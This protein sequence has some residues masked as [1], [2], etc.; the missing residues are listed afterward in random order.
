MLA[1]DLNLLR[2]LAWRNLWR[3]KR[4]TYI[5]LVAISLGAWFMLFTAA[6]VRGMI[7]QQL[8][9]A[10]FTLT[11]HV[12]IHQKKYRDD[13][14]IEHSMSPPGAKLR[15][16]LGDKRISQWSTRVRLPAVIISERESRGT[17][18]VGIDPAHEQG[19]SFI[20]DPVQL[21]RN[22]ESVDDSGVVIGRRMAKR[23]QTEIG[24][25]IVIMA[26][27]ENGDVADRGFRIVGLFTAELEATETAYVFTGR[28]VA[29][30][31]LKMGDKISEIEVITDSRDGLQKLTN[32]LR[33]AAPE[34]ETMDWQELQ[35][36]L[37]ATVEFYD[38][39][40]IIW[41]LIVFL[42][43]SFGLVNTLLMAVFERTRELGLFQALGMR[44]RY[45]VGQV[46][47]ESVILMVLGLVAGNL[48]SWLS[49]IALADGVDLSN[50]AQGLEQF[51]MPTV[52]KLAVTSQDVI[53]AN[54]L[55]I[56]LTLIASLYPAW[57]AARY[58][59]VEAITR[60]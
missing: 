12:Q 27:D 33:S 2:R 35:P 53:T 20:G 59:P 38:A 11:G 8:H 6:F 4:R 54:L 7:E 49:V 41:Y 21:G 56:V 43:M 32:K 23:L 26:Q 52:L 24:R 16:A 10:I 37:V 3:H 55:V 28:Q 29:Q 39:F 30:K 36:L 48:L 42:A 50:F 18:L 9:D 34:L 19:M 57:R 13:P 17:T 40:M 45:I 58:V 14:A 31:M 1:D 44:P 46:M 47:L 5:M 25:R 22:L 15:E 51:S 60:T